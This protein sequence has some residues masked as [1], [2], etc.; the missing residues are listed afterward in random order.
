MAADNI[1][2]A[3][4]S[5]RSSVSSLKKKLS[6]LRIQVEL[7]DAEIEKI[8][9]KFDNVLTQAEIYKAKI[10]RELGRE[11]RRLER[12]LLLSAGTLKAS[13][14][15]CVEN[16][17]DLKVARTVG[18]LDCV[19]RQMCEN[20]DDF[21]LAS[22]AF[23]FPAVYERVMAGEEEAY[24]L[25]EVPASALLII[26]RG[27]EHIEWLREEYNTHLTNAETW[28]D[29]IDYIVEWWR[30][31]ALPLLYGSRDEQ[32]DIDIPL[33]LSEIL[34]WKESPADRP[35][36]FSKIFDAY[37][38]YRKHKDEIYESSG[39]R[40]FELKLFKFGTKETT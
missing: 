16:P 33:T 34:V 5:M 18:I 2:H 17:N 23:L 15:N 14:E 39:L 19:L 28:K 13:A 6:N 27:K 9:A 40:A 1:L 31:D 30:N 26:R 29:S 7:F 38:I 37:E 3:T 11:V 22:E 12:E 20:A 36:N 25:E 8:E 10:E 35:I 32:W 21:R 24:F 4:N